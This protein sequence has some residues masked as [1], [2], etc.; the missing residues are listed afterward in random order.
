MTLIFV[1]LLSGW[2]IEWWCSDKEL[3]QHY[4]HFVPICHPIV[5]LL[6]ENLWGEVGWSTTEAGVH[7]VD[8]SFLGKT[9]VGDHHMPTII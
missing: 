9:K 4:T 6:I 2:S 7:F 8:L 3:V 5:P 1:E